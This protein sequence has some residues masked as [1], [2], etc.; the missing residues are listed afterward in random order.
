MVETHFNYCYP[1]CRYVS[2][3]FYAYRHKNLFSAFPQLF[4]TFLFGFLIV[5][6][7]FFSLLRLL[8]FFLLVLPSIFLFV[9]IVLHIYLYILL[10]LCFFKLCSDFIMSNSLNPSVSSRMLGYV[11]CCSAFS[12]SSAWSWQSQETFTFLGLL[13]SLR[14]RRK[15]KQTLTNVRVLP[16][17]CFSCFLLSARGGKR[18]VFELHWNERQLHFHRIASQQV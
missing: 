17:F 7:I 3:L 6:I 8:H 18:K 4:I 1:S 10:S 2:Y 15:N 13:L 9:F 12:S 14:Q 16:L 5:C 11:R